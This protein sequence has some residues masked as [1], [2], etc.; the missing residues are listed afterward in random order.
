MMLLLPMLY[1]P[2]EEQHARVSGQAAAARG[3]SMAWRDRLLHLNLDARSASPLNRL[4]HSR[5]SPW[6]AT[7]KAQADEVIAVKKGGGGM[8]AGKRRGAV[9]KAFRGRLKIDLVVIG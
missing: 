9:K 8:G 2:G 6:Q 3:L 7:L 4:P 5:R 1:C